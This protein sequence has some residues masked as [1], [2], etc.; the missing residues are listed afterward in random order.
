MSNRAQRRAEARQEQREA[1]EFRMSKYFQFKVREDEVRKK[2]QAELERNGI[3]IKELEQNWQKGFDEGFAAASGQIVK[4]IYAG[5]CLTLKQ[6]HN[7]DGDM[8]ADVLCELDNRIV[9]QLSSEEEIQEVWD[10]LNLEIN[11][12]EPFNRIQEAK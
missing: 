2:K 1:A 11:F 10:Q 12:A 8:C 7:F 4:G 6:L 5:I 3:T 9:T